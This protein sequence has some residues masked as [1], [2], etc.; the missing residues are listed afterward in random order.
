MYVMDADKI[1]A[2]KEYWQKHRYQRPKTNGLDGSKRQTWT[3]T[4]IDCYNAKCICANCQ[5]QRTCARLEKHT[6]NRY[7]KAV[8]RELFAELGAPPER[9]EE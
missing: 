8:V 4:A 2:F 7:M 1:D 6:H 5:N 9:I 3:E